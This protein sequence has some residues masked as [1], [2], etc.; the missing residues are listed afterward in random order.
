M[1]GSF[2]V[3]DALFRSVFFL[4]YS[5]ALVGAEIHT[6]MDLVVFML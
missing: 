5:L 2:G 1:G 3:S 4:A 6:F